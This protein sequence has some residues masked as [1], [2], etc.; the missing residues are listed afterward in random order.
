[1]TGQRVVQLNAAPGVSLATP[2][3]REPT[4]TAVGVATLDS[5]RFPYISPAGDVPSTTGAPRR[6]LVDGGYFDNSGAA[7][8]RDLLLASDVA[9]PKGT[10]QIVRIDGNPSNDERVRCKALMG[11]NQAKDQEHPDW[12]GLSAY[13]NAR[14]A[15]A[16]EAVASLR[17]LASRLSDRTTTSFLPHQDLTLQ[18]AWDPPGPD[19]DHAT[20]ANGAAR[21]LS[22]KACQVSLAAVQA[23][24]GWYMG[25]GTA[26][27]M[28]RSIDA[29]ADD[30]MRAAGVGA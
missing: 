7:S 3:G 8:L 6:L 20:A 4:T 21:A 11:D 29:S 5:A 12:A 25:R 28:Q 16:D 23:P 14:S 19:A 24:L 27:F 9:K 2:G 17:A 22:V 10:V 1:M 18:Y 30:L 13:F 26:E 15:H